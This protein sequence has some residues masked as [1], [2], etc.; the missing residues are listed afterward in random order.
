MKRCSTCK[1]KK[2]TS[3]FYKQR[4]KRDG[5]QSACKLCIKAAFKR[6]YYGKDQTARNIRVNTWREARKADT[7]SKVANYLRRNPCT[8]CG[9]KDIVV[10]EFDHVRGKKFRDVSKLTNQC[11]Q[12]PVVWKEI[13]KCEVVC[14]NCHK[15]RTAKRSGWWQLEILARV[16]DQQKASPA[17]RLLVGAA[18]TTRSKFRSAGVEGRS[19]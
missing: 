3:E 15:R 5:L 16:P 10:L 14:S 9:E 6:F 11:K 12:W 4:S 1:I 13:Q 17:K 7:R 2:P 8:D 18:P 19:D